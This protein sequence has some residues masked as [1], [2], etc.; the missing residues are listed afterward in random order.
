M[1]VATEKPPIEFIPDEQTI[2]LRSGRILVPVTTWAKGGNR[3]FRFPYN[4]NLKDEI[5]SLAGARWEPTE[6]LW[7]AA[8]NSRNQFQIRHLAGEPVY[9]RYDKELTYDGIPLQRFHT[10]KQKDLA[11]F[12]HQRTGIAFFLQRRCGIIAG[13]PGVGK[14]L[15]ALEGIELADRQ[16]ECW[17]VAPKSGLDAVYRDFR[18]WGCSKSPRFLT[19]EAMTKT[20][21]EWKT[22]TKA[23]QIV[24]FDEMSR[25]KNGTS[26]R[27][28]AAM[29][30]A[31]GVR[32]D[33]GDDAY[34]IGMSGTPSPKSPADWYHLC[35]V[36][37]PGFLKEG[38]IHKYKRRLGIII[39]KEGVDGG[40][41]PQLLTW[42]DDA[43]KCNLCGQ[44]EDHECHM[45]ELIGIPGYD[46]HTFV[47]SVN[48]V[49]LLA[50]RLKGLVVV[51]LKKDCLDLPEMHY[52]IVECPPKPS[53][54]RA[55][56]LI[57]KT[58]Q[59]TIQALTRLRE[60]SDGFQYVDTKSGT[61]T[62]TVCNGAKRIVQPREIP[63]TC[64]NCPTEND[65]V[66]TSSFDI[67]QTCAR[68]VPKIENIE[69]SCPNCGGKGETDTFSRHIEEVPCPKDD[70]FVEK[71]LDAYEDV[72]RVVAYGGF[73]GTIDRL[74]RLCHTNGWYVIRM[75]QG[76]VQVTNPKG[77]VLDVD[78]YQS[79]F[80]D[81][82]N[83][84]DKVAFV[85]HP[86][87]GGMAL[88]LTASPVIGVY[89]NDFDGESR[90]QLIHR[91]HRPGMDL[92]LGATIIDFLHLPSDKL[93]L[94]NLTK[95]IKLQDL[96]LGVFVEALSSEGER[97]E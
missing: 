27:S 15:I 83:T 2:K 36:V 69:Q 64:P 90:M 57:A 74:V 89:S 26:L 22:G 82:Q 92:N 24:I 53:T 86:K 95:K 25:L 93:V 10:V 47:P 71:V 19:Y 91:I 9:G 33:W 34:V 35:E 97:K 85:A 77:E 39:L 56:S 8:E 66:R 41:Y 76:K 62:C 67:V 59:T 42:R 79:M 80:Q 11:F 81:Q 13:E 23:P 49:A 14:S 94:E 58:S 55:A 38:D 68:H 3:Y 75:D 6:K 29:A 37:C 21:R 51:F 96:S 73:T 70:A 65:S 18:I 78:D 12:N 72:G 46:V 87:S 43:K 48:E 28:Q 50:E 44:F 32:S 61:Q 52:Q 84:Y 40:S 60:L 30:L 20:M 7:Y 17:Y 63:G 5:K 1:A 4:Q 45:P 16:G 31:N 54:L 88:T